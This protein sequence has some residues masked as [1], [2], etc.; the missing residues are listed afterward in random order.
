MT[1]TILAFVT[2][3]LAIFTPSVFLI[4]R[5]EQARDLKAW[6]QRQQQH[7]EADRLA[8]WHRNRNARMR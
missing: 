2:L 3:F 4:S 5:R 8:A 6:D 7:A 1:I